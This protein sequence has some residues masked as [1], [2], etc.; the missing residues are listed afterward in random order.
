M[1]LEIYTSSVVEETESAKVT[2]ESQMVECSTELIRRPETIDGRYAGMSS[3]CDVD[4]HRLRVRRPGR[5]ATRTS[6]SR[7]GGARPCSTRN[8]MTA[9]LK[10]TRCATRSQWI[11][12]KPKHQ[13]TRLD[14][15]QRWGQT[16]A[17]AVDKL[18]ARPG[19]SFQGRVSS[20]WVTP[21]T[22]ENSRQWHIDAD[23]EA[24]FVGGL[25]WW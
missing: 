5:S 4:E 18:A 21:L 25:L 8:A 1:I 12:A 11:I 6:W 14:E 20:G 10:S 2:T 19:R 3:W 16:G 22:N 9:I 17:V 13:T 15:P 24:D 7:Y 23:D